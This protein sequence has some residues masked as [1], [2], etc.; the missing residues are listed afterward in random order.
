MAVTVGDVID[1]PEVQRGAPE[2]LS[3]SRWSDPIRWLH[4]GDVADLPSLLQGGELVFTTGVG[5][6]HAPKRYL[7]GLAD[8]GALGLVVE[9]GS[10]M[11]AIPPSLPAFARELD[12]ALIT[13]R[14][15]IKFVSVTEVVH[16]RIVAE[17]Y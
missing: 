5:L 2:I 1:L 11:T 10:A 15:Q 13:L 8:A 3:S 9:L 16:R 4:V 12:L 14:H 17:Q 7:Q 6:G